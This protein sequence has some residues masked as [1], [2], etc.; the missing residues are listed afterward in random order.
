MTRRE[1]HIA[2][3]GPVRLNDRHFLASGGE[4]D[5]YRLG[6][7]AIKLYHDRARMIPAA[8]I[9]ELAHIKAFTSHV[10]VPDE[11]VYDPGD[12]Q[13][14]GFT[15]CLLPDAV[16]LVRLFHH[17][18]RRQHGLSDVTPLIEK[19]RAMVGFVH[20]AGC[21][22]V[23][24]NEM[25]LIVDRKLQ[26]PFFIDSDSFQTPSHP[27]TALMDTVRDRQGPPGV[28]SRETDWFSFAV[29][30]FQLY[31]GIHP[32]KGGHPDYKP[33]EWSRRMDDG[34]S[35]F[36]KKAVL[37]PACRD[38]SLIPTVYL[39]WYRD[40]FVAGE[41]KPPPITH[42]LQVA[43][44]MPVRQP[45]RQPDHLKVTVLFEYDEAVMRCCSIFGQLYVVTE[46]GIY[47]NGKKLCS[48]PDG[49]EL[50]MTTTT[51]G[52]PLRVVPVVD[53]LAVICFR[54]R[55]IARI[56]CNA[57]FIRNDILYTA[58]EGQILEHTFTE[59][60]GCI[61]HQ[62]RQTARLCGASAN[63]YDGVAFHRPLGQTWLLLPHARG[64]CVTM[65][66]P[67]LNGFRLVEA[68]SRAH[69]C[70]VVA[71]QKG[72]YHR[73]I[74]SFSKRF[75][76]YAI[77][78]ETIDYTAPNLTV[79]PNRIAVLAVA[80]DSLDLFLDLDQPQRI[81]NT[82]ITADTPLFEHGG[83]VHFIDGSRICQLSMT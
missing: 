5:V 29:L 67:E 27:A 37:P 56:P 42:G 54:D 12:G 66:V 61:V 76:R 30:T 33:G 31:T 69:V 65:A 1:V 45:V 32:Y 23:D 79:L 16:A 20:D 51:R 2:S 82:P 18:F 10:M 26:S 24:M 7:R 60:G 19:I 57:S 52:T 46:T 25:N 77:R 15:M 74:L 64:R 43:P 28:F 83:K 40:L 72:D 63:L 78:T 4:A 53:G 73:F 70:V 35:V 41:R 47:R 34:V 48:Q 58:D 39:D 3:K 75:D 62:S 55:Q 71:E 36:D 9:R 17:A 44:A 49:R 11:V 21:L 50:S 59:I 38:F 8:K 14:I 22:V 6:D 13:P 80:Q 81:G 68:R